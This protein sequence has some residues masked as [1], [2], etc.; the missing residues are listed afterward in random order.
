METRPCMVSHGRGFRGHVV[1][2]DLR[3]GLPLCLIHWRPFQ[4]GGD[5][6]R[7]SLSLAADI[8]VLV[9]FVRMIISDIKDFMA[10]KIRKG[11]GYE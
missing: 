8:A 6:M 1:S 11:M 10:M 9:I 2:A 4:D 7:D 3:S 5:T